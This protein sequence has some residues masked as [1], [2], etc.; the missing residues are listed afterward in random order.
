[1]TATPYNFD[2]IQQLIHQ[3]GLEKDEFLEMVSEGLKV[4][5]NWEDV[6]QSE[7][8]IKHLKRIDKIFSKGLSYYLDPAPPIQSKESSIFFRKEKFG[9]VLNLASKKIVTQFEDMKLS[10]SGMA[11]MSDLK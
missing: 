1:M 10:L 5:L 9:T 4:K 8:Q 11:K 3:F 6:F 7:I 2:R